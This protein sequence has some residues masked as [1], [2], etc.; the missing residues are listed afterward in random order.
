VKNIVKRRTN[1]VELKRSVM[2][3]TKYEFTND[4][5]H[6]SGKFKSGQSSKSKPNDVAGKKKPK[7][8]LRAYT[9]AQIWN[10]KCSSFALKTHNPIRAIVDGLKI[11]PNKDKPMIALSIGR[12]LRQHAAMTTKENI[13]K[14]KFQ[15]ARNLFLMM[16]T[17]Q[18]L[19]A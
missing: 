17:E 2:M 3:A 4:L 11:E 16:A 9:R 15:F 5:L 19:F 10:V 8:L 7:P 6:L 12:C 18:V 13:V 1:I 14:L